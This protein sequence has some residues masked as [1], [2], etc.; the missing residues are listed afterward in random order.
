MFPSL[1]SYITTHP[2]IANESCYCIQGTVIYSVVAYYVTVYNAVPGQASYPTYNLS[3][4]VSSCWSRAVNRSSVVA[5]LWKVCC[6]FGI[7]CMS[8]AQHCLHE[9]SQ[10]RLSVFSTVCMNVFGCGAVCSLS[11]SCRL[12]SRL[13]LLSSPNIMLMITRRFILCC[14]QTIYYSL[15][16]VTNI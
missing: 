1:Y 7:V 15:P 10:H 6:I 3:F 12:S 13:W 4:I 5:W 8:V 11:S 14:I 16:S 2:L 9:Y